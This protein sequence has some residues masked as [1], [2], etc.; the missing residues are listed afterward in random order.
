MAT[1][2]LFGL[3]KSAPFT[4]LGKPAQVIDISHAESLLRRPDLKLIVTS[5]TL[6]AEKFPEYF[7]SCPLHHTRPERIPLNF[8]TQKNPSPT[9]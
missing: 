8:S 3:L 1:D 7:F 9:I 4:V 6:D 2:V 5:A